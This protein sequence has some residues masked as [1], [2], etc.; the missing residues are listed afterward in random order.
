MSN[1]IEVNFLNF[2]DFPVPTEYIINFQIKDKL[3]PIDV[4]RYQE[5]TL[6]YLF[7]MNGGDLLQLQAA[8][9][10][11]DRDWRYHTE[12]RVWLT[13]V[14]GIEPHQKTNSYER[15]VYTLFDVAQW[16]KAQMEMTIEY[17]KLAEKPQLPAQFLMQQQQQ[18]SQ[19]ASSN[20]A[21]SLLPA[22]LQ[23]Q[24]QQQQQQAFSSSL[25]PN[26]PTGLAGITAGTNSAPSF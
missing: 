12:K 6:F 14:P 1:F 25:N 17:C 22:V 8:A 26:T 11:Y 2:P 10:L 23:Q 9:V 24:L 7:Y 13:K 5:D 15:G 19:Q 21:S 20:P 4:T 18:Q 16:R 3:A